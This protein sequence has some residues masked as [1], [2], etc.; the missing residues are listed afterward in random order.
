M[1]CDLTTREISNRVDF[2]YTSLDLIQDEMYNAGADIEYL[3]S[4]ETETFQELNACIDELIR[5]DHEE[6][7]R[8]LSTRAD[9]HYAAFD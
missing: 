1:I 7:S 6:K 3:M 4:I 9:G 8:R 2:L 5:R